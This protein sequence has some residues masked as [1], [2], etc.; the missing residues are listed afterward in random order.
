MATVERFEDLD[1]WKHARALVASVY[2]VTA[3]GDFARDYGLKDQIRRAAVSVMSNIAEG[4]EREGTNEFRQFLATSKGSCGEVQS[5]LY[6][7]LDA[8]FVDQDEFQALHDRAVATG[9]II[10]GL[11]RYLAQTE[12]RGRKFKSSS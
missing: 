5:Q 8:S 2:C 10:G 3:S 6:V 4:F 12:I 1:A 7:A 9:R 11:M